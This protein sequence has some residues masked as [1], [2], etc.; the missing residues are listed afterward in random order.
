[1]SESTKIISYKGKSIKTNYISSVTDDEWK[2]LKDQWYSN[3]DFE[4][5]KYLV[6]EYLRNNN[7]CKQGVFMDSG[8]DILVFTKENA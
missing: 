4:S 5:V 1:M 6:K 2:E 7:R 8:E 3:L